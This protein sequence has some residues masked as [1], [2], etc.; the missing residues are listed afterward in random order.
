MKRRDFL[1]AAGAASAALGIESVRANSDIT[2][3]PF[4][5]G[6]ASGDPTVSG[7]ILWTRLAPDPLNGGGMGN[8]SVQVDFE[9]AT[10]PDMTNIILQGSETA[11]P[12]HNHS[13]HLNLQSF[14]PN[15]QYWY[16]F[17]HQGGLQSWLMVRSLLFSGKIKFL[18]SSTQVIGRKTHNR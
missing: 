14:S 1:R 4:T 9:V 6:V 8:L 15:R 17:R 11:W 7:F 2:Q 18:L 5:L 13:L 12:I 16:R 10:D 3:N